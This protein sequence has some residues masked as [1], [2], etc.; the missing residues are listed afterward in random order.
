MRYRLQKRDDAWLVFF[1]S[2]P[3]KPVNSRVKIWRRLSRAGAVQLKGSVY[4]LPFTEEHVE[5]LQWLVSEIAALKGEAAF[6]RAQRIDT[7]PDDQIVELFNR[8]AASDY[9][10]V[11]KLLDALE[12]KLNVAVQGTGG[13][14]VR[15][16]TN[17]TAKIRRNFE[18]AQRTDFFHSDSGKDL[19]QRIAQA[20]STLKSVV[21]PRKPGAEAAAAIRPR[22]PA[23]FAGRT[24]ATR[25]KP[26]VDR[27]ATA[28]LVRKFIDPGAQFAILNERRAGRPSGDMVLFDVRDGDFTHVG[29]LCTFEVVVR[30]FALKDPALA[31]MA[32]IVHDLDLKDDRYQD[33]AAAGVEE[34]LGG[35][36]KTARDDRD[37]LERGMAVFETLYAAK[38]S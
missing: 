32:A 29:E 37:A 12:R 36:R 13:A 4:I 27:M 7:M 2:I 35:I 18:E 33:P 24:W 16:L 8:R 31:K 38:S 9:Q 25:E 23:D 6:V 11:V 26:F 19:Q 30:A 10:R 17:Q 14:S 34:L 3:S 28:W 5:L 15:G 22:S 1:S 20:L 21:K